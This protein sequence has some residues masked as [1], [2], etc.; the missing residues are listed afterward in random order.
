MNLLL[1]KPNLTIAFQQHKFLFQFSILFI[2][3][4]GLWRAYDMYAIGRFRV[5]GS[6]GKVTLEM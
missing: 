2:C 3:R 4:N 1:A 6:V 5:V